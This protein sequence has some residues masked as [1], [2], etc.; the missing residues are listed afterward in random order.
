MKFKIKSLVDTSCF[1]STLSFWSLVRE[2]LG[3]KPASVKQLKFALFAHFYMDL[4]SE[5]NS[6]SVN[7]EKD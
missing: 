6:K 5:T 1:D 4:P 2:D 7:L 3:S